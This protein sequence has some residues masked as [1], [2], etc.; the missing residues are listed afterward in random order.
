MRIHHLVCLAIL[1]AFG[2]VLHARTVMAD[3]ATRLRFETE[4]PQSAKVL[5]DR[6]SKS[7]GSINM[8]WNEGKIANELTI[9]F[10]RS[11]DFEKVES[12]SKM[13]TPNGLVVSKTV[14]CLGNGDY[15]ELIQ[16]NKSN[17]Y[18]L[19]SIKPSINDQALYDSTHGRCLLAPLGGYQKPLVQMMELGTI[20]LADAYSVP[21]NPSII[22]AKFQVSNDTPIKQFIIRF[23]TANHWAVVNQKTFIREP[24][25]ES[26]EYQV[27]YGPKVNGIAFPKRFISTSENVPYEFGEWV[28]E[29]TPREAFL[30]PHYGLPD[31][32]AL[33]KRPS[34]FSLKWILSIL[35]VIL[36]A[37]GIVLFLKSNRN[38][39]ANS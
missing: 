9:L 2:F 13:Q 3:E 24:L 6:L 23:D 35:I 11:H 20:E 28:F 21:S 33:Q 15:F 32:T 19:K 37:V 8:H 27:E 1:V 7:R 29:E 4:Y 26:N 38:C 36:F 5:V 31:V 17:E 10:F 39:P 22:E 16:K 34:Y 25:I 14:Q 18:I 30:L 12:V